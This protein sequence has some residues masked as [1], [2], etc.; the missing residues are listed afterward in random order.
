MV[1][2][3]KKSAYCSRKIPIYI[4]AITCGVI[5]TIFAINTFSS[6]Q[7]VGLQ[8]APTSTQRNLIITAAINTDLLSVY[9]FARSVRAS[10]SFCTLVMILNETT[11][12]NSD[13]Q[14]L[15][16]AY[17]IV[18][19]S[20]ADYY[21]AKLKQVIYVSRWIMIKNFLLSLQTKSDMFD[22]VFICDSHDSLFQKDI[23]AYM[24][25]SNPGLYAF[26]E[27]VRMTIGTCPIN[28]GWIK[29]C[30]GENELTKL[31]NKSISCAGTVL[32][33][34]SAIMSYLSVMEIE[35]LTTYNGCKGTEADQGLH[36]YIVHNN[37][38]PNT[39]IYQISHEYG[40]LGTLGYAQWLKRNQFGLVL[41]ANGSIYAVIHQW[42]RSKQMVAQ[43]KREYQLIPAYIRNKKQ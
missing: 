24:N 9:R 42:N 35:V 43:F 10:C 25:N 6:N 41:N 30:Y 1:L 22:N 3:V 5:V 8:I 32:G 7:I 11:M 12:S 37:K 39:T 17:S 16:S 40:F 29:A 20:N 19:I 38:I 28:G 18:Y 36:N 2:I 27:D 34:W 4:M 33:T 21:P 15:A 13:F 23:F 26:M 31:F 14:E